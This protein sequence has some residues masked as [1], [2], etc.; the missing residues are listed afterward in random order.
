[1]K[2]KE[3]VKDALNLERPAVVPYGEYAIDFDVIEKLLGRKTYL[4]AKAKSK[5]ALW[6]GRRREVV[7]SWKE[8][9]VELYSKFN[10][11]DIVNLAA[12]AAGLVPS[13]NYEPKNPRKL[14]EKTWED[15]R[16]RI[17]KYSNKTKDITLVKDP[18]QRNK[19][20]A[21][22]YVKNFQEPDESCFEVI[23]YVIS[24]LGEK[25]FIIGPAGRE[26]GMVLLGGMEKGLIK[27]IEKPKLIKRVAEREVEIGKKEDDHYIREGLDAIMW[28][29]DFSYNSGPF[30]SPETF[31]EFVLPYIKIRVKHVKDNFDLPIIK[32]A[33]GN[34]WKLMD[35]FVEA[36]YDGYQSIQA[37]AGMNIE[38]LVESY[39]NL[40]CMWGGY[41]YE[42]LVSGDAEKIKKDIKTSHK[43]AQNHGGFI[44]GSSHSVGVGTK[45]E[46][47]MTV[48]GEV[49]KIKEIS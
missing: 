9:T 20:Q 43:I 21:E 39:G 33:C 13:K 26:V 23:D 22:D 14:D 17:Y 31:E 40:I 32:H 37:S 24:K 25:K 44:L 27:Y 46:N 49:R 8:D 15:H 11:I 10:C 29:Q 41:N 30:I 45:Y 48:I 5:L 3:I 19:N 35:Y 38:E 28:G 1:M 16:G 6:S 2:S 12:E 18:V 7:E 34:N 42:D 4:R 47:F 36:G